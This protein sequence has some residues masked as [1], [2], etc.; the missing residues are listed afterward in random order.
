MKDDLKRLIDDEQADNAKKQDEIMALQI[1]LI[2]NSNE[3][4][5]AT[6]VLN[7]INEIVGG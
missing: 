5:K 3:I 4:T 1:G 6:H 2:T 7:K